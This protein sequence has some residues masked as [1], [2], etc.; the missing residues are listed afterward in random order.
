MKKITVIGAGNCSYAAAA[1]LALKG[2]QVNMLVDEPHWSEIT[3]V[4]KTRTVELHEDNR[5]QEAKLHMVT[6][7]PQA[8]IG[9]S[10]L[11][12]ITIPAYGHEFITQWICD[13]LS[14]DQT[15]IF[16][17]GFLASLLLKKKLKE[18]GRGKRI[19][20]AETN[21]TPYNAKKLG[22]N[23]VEISGRI[24]PLLTAAVPSDD[25]AQ[26]LAEFES[27]L[28]LTKADHVFHSVLHATN[29]CYH[30]PG[31]V[32]NTGR[33]ERAK[34]EFY[35]Y[36]E[37]ITPAV[38]TVMEK[39]DEERIHILKALGCS[40][41]SVPE[42]MA[43]GRQARSMWE[44]INGCQGLEF[45]KGPESLQ[46]RYLTEDIPYGLMSWSMIG[47]MLELN[48]P[49]IEALIT[50]GGIVIGKDLIRK[51]QTKE[52]LGLEELTRDNLFLIV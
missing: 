23:R 11:I 10:D 42:E 37:G 44:E 32:L 43:E 41:Y 39:L 30:V 26:V 40:Y 17:P 34:G 36:E 18:Q 15:V 7:D 28:P 46:S 52:K 31:C 35:L 51:G 48:L 49:V 13:Y 3:A 24:T 19:F 20:V 21:E 14:D 45:V 22:G 47:R 2:N 5:T 33:I 27:I 12:L 1:D 29:P 4:A 6:D 50:L 38:A 16:A 8:A 25:T 9:G